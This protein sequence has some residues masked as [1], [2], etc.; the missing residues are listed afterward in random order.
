[1]ISTPITWNGLI[2]KLASTP[3]G[4]TKGM[5]PTVSSGMYC[6]SMNSIKG[7]VSARVLAVDQE[8]KVFHQVSFW[9]RRNCP[10]RKGPIRRKPSNRKG[11]YS[12]YI[13]AFEGEGQARL[14]MGNWSGYEADYKEHYGK[15]AE[16]LQR[17]KYR[18]LKR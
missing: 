10:C 9:E 1:M 2:V 14:F 6:I 17:I 8:T 12:T 11:K 13:L 3:P 4:P 15:S 7:T 16:V 18:T 5:N